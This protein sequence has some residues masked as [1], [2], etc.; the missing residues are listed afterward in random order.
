MKQ[1]ILT[2][3]ALMSGCMYGWACTNLIV[4][5]N[6]STDGSVIVSYNADSYG[7]YGIM[8]HYPAAKHPKGSMR[9]V[10]NWETDKLVG[11][12]EEAEETYNVVGNIN[13]HQVTI[14]E[15][16]FGGRE[17]L[18]DTT[19]FLDYGSMIYITLQR[20]KTAREALKVM[21]DLV[22]KYGYASSG[23]T[24]TIA[25]PKE[26]WVMEMV[27]KG[28]GVKGAV[29]VA[30]RI[31]DDCICAHAN[32]SRIHQF[33]HYDK[34]DCMYSKDVVTFAK[35]K[36]FFSGKDADFD[37]ANAYCP[38]DFGGARYCEARAWSFFN[39]WV[40]GMDKY[41]NYAAGI[42]LSAEPFPLFMKPKQK[43][44]VSDVEAGMR[45]QYEGTPLEMTNDPGA[46]AWKSPYRPRPLSWEYK[47][48]KYFNE[49]PIG[50]Q[51]SSF[52]FVA[53]MRSWLPDP[54][55]GVIWFGNDDAQMVAYTPVYCC[56]TEAPACYTKKY[57]DDVT[58]SLKS[59][60][61]VCNWVANMV[62]PRYSLM[63]GDVK[64]VRD[65]LEQSYFAK[66]Q[67]VE[68]KAQELL[69]GNRKQG[70]DYLTQYSIETANNM[71]ERWIKLGEFLI[72]KYNDMV[73]KP[74]KDGRFLRTP[75]GLGEKVKSPGYPDETKERIVKETG[76]K[77]Q[78][79]E[80]KD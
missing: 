1:I 18:V 29:W 71:M 6:A 53:Q 73:V 59:A 78:V 66:Q 22:E 77:Y 7:C 43:L 60:F 13:E 79:P 80:K 28:P 50:T 55:G 39:R 35:K 70:V 30:V 34:A 74:E 2:I 19:A 56:A 58:F 36:G 27:G 46:G 16:T 40:E 72:V 24:F 32:Q 3:V 57:G 47:G 20:S 54:V 4:G 69:S 45:D 25:D 67:E 5:R 17:E 21:T 8:Q 12:I 33:M 38:L 37:F 14:G 44:S 31:P 49:R 9:K 65:E 42:D 15:T 52:T 76:N 62:Y 64:K 23:E 41:F 61:W 51:Q 63:F 11:E 26:V 75:E 68:A 48:T 10:F